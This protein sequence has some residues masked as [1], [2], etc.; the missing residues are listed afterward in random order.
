[1]RV[2]KRQFITD[3]A[4]NPIGVILPLEEYT[5]VADT[6]DQQLSAQLDVKIQQVENAMDDPLFRADLSE[7]MTAFE[8]VDAEWWEEQ[9]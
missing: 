1:M 7:T 2:L 4:G 5:L 6:L 9:R 8:H 3:E